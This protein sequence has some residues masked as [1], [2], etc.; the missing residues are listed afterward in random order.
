MDSV[1]LRESVFGRLDICMD[2]QSSFGNRKEGW[3]D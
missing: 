3:M 2:E 1:S